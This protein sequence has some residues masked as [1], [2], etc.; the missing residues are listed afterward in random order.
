MRTTPTAALVVL[1]N[2][3]PVHI[4]MKSEAKFANY[5]LNI[6]ERS[7]LRKIPYVSLIREHDQDQLL[8]DPN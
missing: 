6:T 3:P 8:S 7:H 2:L 4:F 1:F 5:K